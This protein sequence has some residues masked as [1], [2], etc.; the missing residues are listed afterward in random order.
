[1]RERLTPRS[2]AI[3][4]GQSFLD[5]RYR[6][7]RVA[8]FVMVAQEN[9]GGDAL[10]MHNAARMQRCP[11]ETILLPAYDPVPTHEKRGRVDYRRRIR[12]YALEAAMGRK[13]RSQAE[14]RKRTLLDRR[15]VSDFVDPEGNPSLGL[16]NFAK[17]TAGLGFGADAALH[18][19]HRAETDERMRD[20]LDA[21]TR[22]LQA[23]PDGATT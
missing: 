19:P 18:V 20:K 7:S 10:S 12:W 4:A 15:F 1:M 17:L 16:D 3:C 9:M 2:R 6:R 22:S 23:R 13:V 5:L 8:P 11:S 21:F 14:L